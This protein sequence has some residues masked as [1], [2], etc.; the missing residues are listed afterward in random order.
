MKKCDFQW[1]R[2]YSLFY[3][4]A[5][6]YG[7]VYWIKDELGIDVPVRGE[8]LHSWFSIFSQK[9][10]LEKLNKKLLYTIK[11]STNIQK[12]IGEVKEDV[13]VFFWFAYRFLS[14]YVM[15]NHNVFSDLLILL[16]V[17][18]ANDAPFI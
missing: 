5:A 8:G 6:L 4:V 14:G 9:E 3:G 11:D 16:R 12:E 10:T 15:R 18:K 1:K 17:N 7:L 2:E 13:G